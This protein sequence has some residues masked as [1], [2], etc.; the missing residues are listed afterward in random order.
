MRQVKCGECGQMMNKEGA[1]Y[2]KPKYY[3]PD[4]YAAK[5]KRRE[6]SEYV[7]RLFNLK[8]PGPAIHR[9]RKRY[10][11]ELGM[12]DQDI[13]NTLK[14][15]YEV[16]RLPIDK[17]DERI[18]VV[19]FLADEA[20]VYFERQKAKQIE[21]ANMAAA[22]IKKSQQTI[23]VHAQSNNSRRGLIDPTELLEED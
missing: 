9:Q 16:K 20:R 22:N 5:L 18:G 1:A 21:I 7:C 14:Y 3:H 6:F 10:I 12:T 2:E 4:C 19:P 17:A 13:I 23:M 15:A 8:A 11:E